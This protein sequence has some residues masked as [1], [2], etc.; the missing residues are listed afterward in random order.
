MSAGIAEP[1]AVITTAEWETSTRA[2]STYASVTHDPSG[3]TSGSSSTALA[4]TFSFNQTAATTRAYVRGV[5]LSTDADGLS[6]TAKR[7]GLLGAGSIA[8]SG[9]LVP[10]SDS[11][12]VA[13]NISL[14][15]TNDVTRAFL[16]GVSMGTI[17]QPTRPLRRPRCCEACTSPSS[18]KPTA[19]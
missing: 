1:A 5:Q 19:C 8:F 4:G 13:A 17:A 2:P 18:T 15:F 12:A 6:V 9:A 14:N 11:T 3:A 10:G 16:Q 7:T